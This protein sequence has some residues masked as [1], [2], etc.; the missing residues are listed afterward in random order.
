MRRTGGAGPNT[1]RMQAVT[2]LNFWIRPALIVA[3]WIVAAAFTLSELATAVPAI[4]G[5]A[6]HAE[7]PPRTLRARTAQV[8]RTAAVEP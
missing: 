3:L 4:T 5:Q 7:M 1:G 8:V 6:A 2:K